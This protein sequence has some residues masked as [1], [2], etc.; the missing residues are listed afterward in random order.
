MLVGPVVPEQ[1]K[2]RLK[3]EE[4]IVCLQEARS[5]GGSAPHIGHNQRV[6][7]LCNRITWILC[8]FYESQRC[9]F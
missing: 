3:K 5:D 6:L 7:H 4:S 2:E 1:T 9:R 8:V